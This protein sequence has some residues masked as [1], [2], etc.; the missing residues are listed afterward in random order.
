MMELPVFTFSLVQCCVSGSSR[1]GIILPDL[2]P[3]SYQPNVKLSL[4]FSIHTGYRYTI[5]KIRIP[6]MLTRK[7]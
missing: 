5:L 1:I 4:S 7:I 2:D 6:L 3:Y